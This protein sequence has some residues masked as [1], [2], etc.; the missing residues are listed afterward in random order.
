LVAVLVIAFPTISFRVIVGDEPNTVIP[1]PILN[2]QFVPHELSMPAP[3][4]I[5]IPSIRLVSA[6]AEG[7]Y[8]AVQLVVA[9]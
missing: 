7:K 2:T 3:P 1:P 9:R 4:V 5:R 8:T 6:A